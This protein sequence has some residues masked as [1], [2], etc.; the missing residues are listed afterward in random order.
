[1]QRL[2]LKDKNIFDDFFS[3]LPIRLS[4]YSFA[5]IFVWNRLFDIYWK[6]IDGSL[7]IFFENE[8]GIFLPVEP[9]GKPNPG[10]IKKVFD[11]LEKRNISNAAS[12]IENISEPRLKF[13]ESCRLHLRPKACEY[14]YD[15]SRLTSLVGNDFKSKRSSY[16]FFVKNYPFVFK[17]LDAS[18]ADDC[19]RLYRSWQKERAAKFKDDAYRFCLEDSFS[20]QEQA[21][22]NFRRLGFCG[23]AIEVDG[24]I[25]GYSAGVALD[26]STFY[27]MFETAD[28]S[29]KGLSTFLFRNFC[30]NLSEFKFINAGDDSGF[31]NLAAVKHSYKPAQVLKSFIAERR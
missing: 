8:L 19:L 25:K 31:E 4:M 18:M 3:L 22:K 26:K 1:M 13:Y 11:I 21:F 23:Q 28:L 10:V 9:L 6:I 27:I 15:S 7:C 17:T 24:A 5:S 30:R 2:S 29:I 14:I 12:R 16:N 20:A